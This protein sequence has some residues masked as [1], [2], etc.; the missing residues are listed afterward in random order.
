MSEQQ[1]S[2]TATQTAN[3]NTRTITTVS[4]RGEK[5]EISFSGST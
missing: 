4:T 2:G 1:G 5:T 3:S